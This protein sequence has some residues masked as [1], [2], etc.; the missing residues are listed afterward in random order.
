MLEE[1]CDNI[2]KNIVKNGATVVFKTYDG[3]EFATYASKSYHRLFNNYPWGFLG[4]YDS[5]C[6]RDW[7]LDDLKGYM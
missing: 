4:L 6:K 3:I 7:L 2:L 1:V 5:N